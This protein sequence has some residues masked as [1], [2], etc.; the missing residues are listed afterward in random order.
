MPID[1]SKYPD[2]DCSTCSNKRRL[3]WTGL[4]SGKPQSHPC[5]DCRPN[6]RDTPEPIDEN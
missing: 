5:P 6:E 1:Y 4:V 2:A 3:F